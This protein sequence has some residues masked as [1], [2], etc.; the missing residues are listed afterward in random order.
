MRNLKGCLNMES[1]SVHLKLGHLYVK[2]IIEGWKDIICQ[3][4]L[5]SVGASPSIA[6]TFEMFVDSSS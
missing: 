2:I 5:S 4:N 6:K 3:P 1:W